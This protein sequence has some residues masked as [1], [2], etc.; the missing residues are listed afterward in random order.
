VQTNLVIYFKAT[1]ILTGTSKST[2]DSNRSR[3]SRE[4]LNSPIECGGFGMIQYE[5]VLAGIA[6]RQLAKLYDTETM[7]PLKSL[8]IKNDSHFATGIS[9]T[10]IADEIAVKAHDLLTDK[11]LMNVKRMSNQQITQDVILINQIG[12][13]DISKIVKPRWLNSNQATELIHIHNCNN[14]RDIIAGGRV[15]VQLSKKIL[16]AQFQRY[17]R[18]FWNAGIRCQLITN[19]K[20]ALLN[21]KYKQIWLVKSKEFRELLNGDNRLTAPKMSQQSFY[22]QRKQFNSMEGRRKPLRKY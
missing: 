19:D 18:I 8:T 12:A 22:R 1:F 21:G 20:I 17:V 15:T 4:R 5:Q 6:C 2:I 7:H 13:I 14:I 11:F 16:K 3:I 10:N 9:L